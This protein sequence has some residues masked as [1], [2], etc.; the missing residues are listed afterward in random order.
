MTEREESVQEKDF[1]RCKTKE[2]R[3]ATAPLAA[4]CIVSSLP[5]LQTKVP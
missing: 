4:T 5:A 2:E 1:G 3:V